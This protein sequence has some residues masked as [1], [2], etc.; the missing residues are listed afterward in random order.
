MRKTINTSL[1][2]I[3]EK[4]NNKKWSIKVTHENEYYFNVK[5][6]KVIKPCY[7]CKTE[8]HNSNL[9]VRHDKR[10]K[11]L[12]VPKPFCKKCVKLVDNLISKLK[13]TV[14]NHLKIY[15]K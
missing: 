1:I 9:F 8:F 4:T 5:F 6:I 11:G 10:V 14:P 3:L 15:S 13:S 12:V 2:E 7:F